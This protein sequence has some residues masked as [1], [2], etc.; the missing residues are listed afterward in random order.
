M[1]HWA[2]CPSFRGSRAIPVVDVVGHLRAALSS[3]TCDNLKY[4]SATVQP[5]VKK[6]FL[7]C[8]LLGIAALLEVVVLVF[9]VEHVKGYRSLTQLPKFCHPGNSQGNAALWAALEICESAAFQH[10]TDAPGWQKSLQGRVKSAKLWKHDNQMENMLGKIYTSL[11]KENGEPRKN[12]PAF[13]PDRLMIKF[14]SNF[15]T[16]WPTPRGSSKNDGCFTRCSAIEP[17]KRKKSSIVVNCC[18][19]RMACLNGEFREPFKAWLSVFVVKFK[20]KATSLFGV[21]YYIFYIWYT[22]PKPSNKYSK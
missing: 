16:A 2:T 1:F 18:R 21:A 19:P 15:M 10:S 17:A 12:R 3:G 13:L 8:F 11:L 7:T 14:S 22:Y 6:R 20:S 9:D 4:E 5:Y